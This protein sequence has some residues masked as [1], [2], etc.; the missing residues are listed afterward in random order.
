[1]ELFWGDVWLRLKSLS[2]KPVK[3]ATKNSLPTYLPQKVCSTSCAIKFASNKIKR[4]EEKDRKKRLSEERKILRARKEKLKTKSDWNKEAQAAV[5][6]Y[7]FLAR[8]WSAMYCLR[9]ALKL[10]SK[11]WVRRCQS[12]Q[13]KGFGKS[14]KI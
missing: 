3:S 9:S 4:T 5:N 1:M 8:L 11:R 6:K 10:W 2:S 7:I 14:F 13:V 12:L